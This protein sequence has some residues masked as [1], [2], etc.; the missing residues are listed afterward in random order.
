VK[1]FISPRSAVAHGMTASRLISLPL[2]LI[3]ILAALPVAS[4]E[5]TGSADVGTATVHI[6]F[7]ERLTVTVTNTGP[8]SIEVVSIAV[9]IDWESMPTLYKVFEGSA[10]LPPGGTREFV[11]PSTRM[12]NVA[13][14]TYHCFTGVV[15]KGADGLAV[16]HRYSDV[17][18]ADRFSL[19]VLGMPEHILV[20][21]I[22]TALSSL[23]TLLLFRLERTDRWPFLTAVPR[24]GGQRSR[25]S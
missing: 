6:N 22:L 3:I 11:S 19:S 2:L 9:T 5:W 13:L 4:G 24:W 17:I 8:S 12:P 10:I 25:R 7:T 15:A 18:T 1:R 16:E 20:P 23:V 14:G 21:L